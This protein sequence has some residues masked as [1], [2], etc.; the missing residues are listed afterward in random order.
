MEI[1][2][3]LEVSNVNVQKIVSPVQ[4]QAV[5]PGRM[6]ADVVE[7]KRKDP[8][9]EVMGE[10]NLG[11]PEEVQLKENIEKDAKGKEKIKEA[12]NHAI[13]KWKK[14]IELVEGGVVNNLI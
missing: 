13:S 7:G 2:E 12:E 9:T 8:K 10:G 14:L 5:V 3:G 4:I 1:P 6:F 11:N